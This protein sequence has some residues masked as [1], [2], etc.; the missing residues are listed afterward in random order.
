MKLIG[1]IAVI[2]VAGVAL[3]YFL[4][5]ANPT[6]NQQSTT[7]VEP[8]TMDKTPTNNPDLKVE[9]IEVGT[10]REVKSGDTVVMHYTGTLTDGTKF[11]SSLDRGTPFET[12]IGV[13]RVIQGWDE[14]VPGM[15]IGGKRK[16]TIPAEM[17]YGAAGAGDAIPPNSTLIFEVELLDIK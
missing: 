13:G 3:G 5:M 11:D 8:T 14:G 6:S 4:I 15:K 1:I 7:A 10:G 12:Q 16:L 2:I 9:D 17:G